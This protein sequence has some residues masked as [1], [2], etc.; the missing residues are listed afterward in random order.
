MNFR[1]IL[2]N[3]FPTSIDPLNEYCCPRVCL[4]FVE[5]LKNTNNYIYMLS[6][7]FFVNEKNVISRKKFIDK[8]RDFDNFDINLLM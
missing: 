5:N 3:T 6:I 8:K 4:F 2:W 7:T 1:V